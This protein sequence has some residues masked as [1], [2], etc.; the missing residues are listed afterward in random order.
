[1]ETRTHHLSHVADIALLDLGKK[2]EVFAIVNMIPYGS[3]PTD[4]RHIPLLS[5]S[6]IEEQSMIRPTI[7]IAMLFT[8]LPSEQQDEWVL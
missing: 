5:F 2:V 6:R 1:V 7:G 4:K 3:I 8:T